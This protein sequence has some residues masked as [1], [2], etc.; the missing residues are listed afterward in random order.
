MGKL[1]NNAVYWVMLETMPWA[2]H[3][4][5]SRAVY[6]AAYPVVRDAVDEAVR[7]AVIRTV[8]GAV[9]ETGNADVNHP[10]LSDFLLEAKVEA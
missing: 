4:A 2:V 8:G 1:T 6:G 7:V 10:A 5:V 3:W 9:E